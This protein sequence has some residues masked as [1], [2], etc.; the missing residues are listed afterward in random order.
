M[1]KEVI[2]IAAELLAVFVKGLFKRSTKSIAPT[3]RTRHGQA[4]ATAAKWLGYV[5]PEVDKS[6]TDT[7]TDRSSATIKRNIV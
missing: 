3:Q 6:G 2:I 5:E 4:A 7:A 1:F